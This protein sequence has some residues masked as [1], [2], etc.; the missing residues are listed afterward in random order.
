LERAEE[1]EVLKP[2]YFITFDITPFPLADQVHNTL[3]RT[4]GG[5]TGRES[6]FYSIEY[7]RGSKSLFDSNLDVNFAFMHWYNKIIDARSMHCYPELS[8]LTPGQFSELAWNNLFAYLVNSCNL[9]IDD[10]KPDNRRD[11]IGSTLFTPIEGKDFSVDLACVI[12]L[13][14]RYVQEV[15]SKQG[16]EIDWVYR[17]DTIE[18]FHFYFRYYMRKYAHLYRRVLVLDLTRYGDIDDLGPHIGE[19]ERAIR[20]EV[21]S[22]DGCGSSIGSNP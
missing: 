10:F 6:R 15:V 18:L 16:L 4:L 20:R 9:T 13:P 1:K 19:L 8:V 3:L 17:E 21:S 2:S 5:V 7:I 22:W 11:I 12:L 14:P